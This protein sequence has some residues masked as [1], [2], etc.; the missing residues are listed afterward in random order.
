MDESA[1]KHKKINILIPKLLEQSNKYA[2]LFKNKNKINN[3]LT[4]FEIKSSNQFNYFVKDSIK[5]YKNMKLGNN[6][7]KI[8]S[9]TEKRRISQANRV[10]A[11]NFFSNTII[12]QEK[13]NSKY[14]TLDKT[15]KNLKKTTKLLK[16][17]ALDKTNCFKNMKIDCKMG[18]TK[19]SIEEEKEKIA[20]CMSLKEKLR[21]GKEKINNVFK[22]DED[23]IV[24]MFDK[25][26]DEVKILQQ[27]GEKSQEKYSSMHKKLELVL[28]K[29]EMI[30]YKHYEPPKKIEENVEIL[31]RK[32]LEN[33]MPF[34]KYNNSM[35]DQKNKRNQSNNKEKDLNKKKIFKKIQINNNN[36]RFDPK[37]KTLTNSKISR[38]D[39]NDTNDVVYNTA[40]KELTARE[41]LN[42]KS[43]K[44]TEILRYEVPKIENYKSIIK[45]K[46][47]EIKNRRNEINNK[48]I[49]EQ[50]KEAKTFTD[51]LND[52]IDNE[53]Y[54]LTQIEKNQFKMPKKE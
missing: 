15:Y 27:I 49:K 25:Y 35:S 6:L 40:Y 2:K 36:I 10:L 41:L 42:D 54:L 22:I 12:K 20:E 31:Q 52:K 30:N 14:Y 21:E 32:T 29:L 13:M 38:I 39:M 24:K 45:N 34:T 46:F 16:D 43:K 33:L 44:I 8:I 19:S 17:S 37:M 47:K 18:K 50:N 11:D 48:K 9:N 28:P 23:N 4:E 26:R 5:R 7:Y 53:I 51:I 3:I 1:T